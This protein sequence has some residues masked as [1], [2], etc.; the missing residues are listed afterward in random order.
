M[1]PLIAYLIPYRE[2]SLERRHNLFCVLQWVLSLP[3]VTPIVIE[4]DAY[5]RLDLGVLGQ[6]VQFLFLYNPGPF[7]KGWAFN[8]GVKATNH[9]LIAC[10]DADV[11]APHGWAGAVSALEKTLGAAKPYRHLVDL[12]PDE[13]QRVRSG[14]HLWVPERPAHALD[15]T[16]KGE[17]LC[18]AGG[19]FVLHR[20]LY[21]SVAGFDERFSGWGGEDD[22]MSIRLGA[23]GA[24][25][26][27]VDG[28]PALH[29]WHPR[30]TPIPGETAYAHNLRTLSEYHV[31][32]D[33]Q[34]QRLFEIQSSLHGDADKYRP[35]QHIPSH[36]FT[37]SRTRPGPR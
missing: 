32:S 1:N 19:L 20:A 36:A 7:N 15:R 23:S 37:H 22:A 34:R 4:Q 29:L 30:N 25:L 28:P 24:V 13:T 11:L 35:D 21:L 18:F 10:G 14:A 12:T 5:P 2:D 8:V 17:M 6:K 26:G 31:Y 9:P 3:D 27:G 33:E 16:Q